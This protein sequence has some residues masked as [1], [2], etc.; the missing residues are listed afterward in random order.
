MRQRRKLTALLLCAV[1]FAL[2]F[3][4]CRADT[5]AGVRMDLDAPV[6]NLDP[7]F[8]TDPAAHMILANLFEGLMVRGEGGSLRLGAAERMEVSLDGTVYA[9]TLRE[10]ARWQCGE[11]VVAQDFVFAFAR[12]FSSGA[13]SPFADDF[14]AIAG[15]QRILDG[16]APVQTLGVTAHGTYTVVFTLEHPQ[17]SFPER[18]AS[19]AA[20]PCNR[21]AFEQSRGRYGLEMRYVHS[22]GPFMLTRWDA[23]RLHLE[24]NEYFREPAL[25]ERVTLYIGRADPFQQFLD[26]RSDI[27]LV[28]PGR[29]EEITE[30][31][32]QLIPAERTV[33]G[34]VFNQN[35]SPW[36]NPLARQ[37][38]ML[39]LDRGVYAEHLIPALRTAGAL[40]PPGVLLDGQSYRE[41]AGEVAPA[42]D[43]EQG[44]RLLRRWL[45]IPGYERLPPTMLFAPEAHAL[46]VAPLEMMWLRELNADITVVPA[47]PEQIAERLRSGNYGLM[48]LP[49]YSTAQ[50]PGAFLRTFQSGNRFGHNSP[51]F[52][53]ALGSA[54]RAERTQAAARYY[55]DAERTL[56]E[57]AAIIPLFFETSY[58]ALAHGLGGIEISP[59]GGRILFRNAEHTN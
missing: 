33:W 22:N 35:T 9:F 10:D 21:H 26:G 45:E 54:A 19:P 18:L 7:Q 37:S 20:L 34:L 23:T 17:E 57:D 32:V 2:P 29:Q 11:R 13:R 25:P 4:G 43:P 58:Y 12:L 52:D 8:A 40:V 38:L 30:R 24:P 27:V 16:Q 31:Q 56:L 51:R 46:R 42:H 49:I 39:T 1:L 59:L 5:L 47:E 53:H 50:G 3:S 28:P 6:Q 55:A 14:L 36:G 41:L 48:L 44:R 15:A